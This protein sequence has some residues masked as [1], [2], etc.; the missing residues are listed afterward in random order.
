MFSDLCLHLIWFQPK[1]HR[2]LS[3]K[4]TSFHNLKIQTFRHS[5]LNTHTNA[6]L[7]IEHAN[8]DEYNELIQFIA[9]NE[10]QMQIANIINAINF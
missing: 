2:L 7:H 5:F 4:D 6:Y 8:Y 10:T 3:L 1:T 9:V